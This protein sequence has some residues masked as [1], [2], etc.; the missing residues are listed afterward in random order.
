MPD[1]G[2]QRSWAGRGRAV[3]SFFLFAILFAILFVVVGGG[4]GWIVRKSHGHVESFFVRSIANEACVLLPLLLATLAMAKLEKRKF[5]YFGLGSRRAVRS[6]VLGF[7][8]GAIVLSL[9]LLSLKACGTFSFGNRIEFGRSA[10]RFAGL[11]LL[12]F[13]ATAFIEELLFRGYA[14]VSLSKAVGFWPA[15]IVLS[16]L[17]AA[18][19]L[20]NG[21]ENRLGILSTFL[22][23]LVIGYSFRWS[24]TLWFAVGLHFGWDY[25]Q[26]FVFGVPDSAILYP[27]RLMNPTISGPAWLTGGIA[28]PEGSLLMAVV[29]VI[30]IVVIRFALQRQDRS[31]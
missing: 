23:S 17:F 22:F 24:G 20:I 12:L 5:G 4:V 13:S 9:M 16:A 21:G 27:G 18:A 29:Y 1:F 15:L 26:S 2:I 3:G 8:C 6:G 10:I 28:G 14:L 30:I 25:F 7:C 31:D 11:H 19:H